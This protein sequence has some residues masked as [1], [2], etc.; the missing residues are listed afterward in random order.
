MIFETG[1]ETMRAVAE[2]SSFTKAARQLGVTGPA[3]SKKIKQ[4]EERLSLTLF[5]RT[6][7]SVTLTESW[8][9]IIFSFREKQ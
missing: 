4:L 1:F 9:T 6:T 7:R 5:H 3:V 8:Q 2:N